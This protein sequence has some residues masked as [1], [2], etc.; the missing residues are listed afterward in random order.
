M[1]PIEIDGISVSSQHYI[2]GKRVSSSESFED[3]SPID[4][5]LL[6]HVAAG[7]DEHCDAAIAAAEA[8]FPAWAAL[9]PH[10]RKAHLLRFAQGIRSRGNDLARV[11]SEDN[12]MLLKRLRGHGVDRT[13][14]N[15]EFFAE[16]AEE[17]EKQAIDGDKARH[18]V[19]HDPAG[20]CV[21][22][23]PWN[24]PLMLT[25]WKLGP[26]LAAGNTVVVKPPEP[27]TRAP[28]LSM[29]DGTMVEP[30][31]MVADTSCVCLVERVASSG[32]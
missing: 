13:A 12:G 14:H 31:T 6:G 23:T 24:S 20:V 7:L 32:M 10:G 27:R 5:R 17:I 18:D 4:G 1:R 21:L 3:R 25:T 8:A 28:P 2:G 11:E 16:L 30:V 19:Q 26:A 29:I 9:G 15:I 22:I